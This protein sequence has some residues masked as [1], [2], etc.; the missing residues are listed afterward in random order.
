MADLIERIIIRFRKTM[1]MIVCWV[2][3]MKGITRIVQ[4][5]NVTI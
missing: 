4:T 1:R 2:N 3:C 5:E